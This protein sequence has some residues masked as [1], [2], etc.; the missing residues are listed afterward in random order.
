[1]EKKFKIAWESN[2]LPYPKGDYIDFLR[3]PWG[4]V[5]EENQWIYIY[6]FLY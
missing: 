6:N 5:N 4:W 1:M 3:S 2:Y